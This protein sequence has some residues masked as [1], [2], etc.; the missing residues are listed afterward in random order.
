M[1]MGDKTATT[2][3]YKWDLEEDTLLGTM[4][5]SLVSRKEGESQNRKLEKAHENPSMI[6]RRSLAVLCTSIT[7]TDGVLS[8]PLQAGAQL[9]PRCQEVWRKPLVGIDD[10]LVVII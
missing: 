2:L 9:L 7:S 8:A 4:K 5:I 1:K 6:T 3:G 10:E